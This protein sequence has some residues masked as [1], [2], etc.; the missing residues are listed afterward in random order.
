MTWG[1]E[2][3]YTRVAQ[4]AIGYEL[5]LLGHYRITLIGTR[6]EL[7]KMTPIKGKYRDADKPPLEGGFSK[8]G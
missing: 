5:V 6:N 7:S 2:P 1:F 4:V 3:T 8:S